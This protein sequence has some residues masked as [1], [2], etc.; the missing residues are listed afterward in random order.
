M[1]LFPNDQY[2]ISVSR[3]R[4]LLT[5]DC[6]HSWCGVLLRDNMRDLR[7]EKRLT[8][9]RE[10][11][12]GI[13]CL[14]VASN[15]TTVI[16][17]GQEKTLTT[18]DLR[19]ADPVR[20]I[21][22]DEEVLALSMT[23]DDAFL[24]TAGTG[25]TVKV[26]DIR[27]DQ[28]W[29]RC[30]AVERGHKLRVSGAMPELRVSSAA[31]GEQLLTAALEE[32]ALAS[33]LAKLLKAEVFRSLGV[34]AVRQK[35]FLEGQE[36]SEG[37]WL[38][39]GQPSEVFVVLQC[40]AQRFGAEL[41]SAAAA[42]DAAMVQRVLAQYQ[43]P[44]CRSRGLAP[45][46]LA[47]ENGHAPCLRLLLA[48]AADLHAADDAGETALHSAAWRGQKEAAECLLQAGAEAARVNENQDTALH[49]AA[50]NGH[51]AVAQLLLQHDAP[52]NAGNEAGDTP[53][54]LAAQSGH[55][56][57][58]RL[59]LLRGADLH[60]E[61]TSGETPLHLA[62]WRGQAAVASAL[63]EAKA[64]LEARSSSG[65]SALILGAWGGHRDLCGLLLRR[66]AEAQAANLRGDTALVLALRNN[67]LGTAQCLL[68]YLPPPLPKEAVLEVVDL[69]QAAERNQL[70]ADLAESPLRA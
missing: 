40:A 45:L 60:A 62:A 19:M 50:W 25:Q 35:L 13:N 67:D 41:V 54:H 28:A 5:W 11:H 31:S 1:S 27:N 17:A 37:S 26:W 51:L 7:A 64:A 10:R 34:P 2:A 63:L 70:A 14:A 29:Y 9:H 69:I 38:S 18:W 3:D 58:V 21:D 8:A 46:H 47:A 55:Q 33:S 61:L 66:N 30:P 4:C 52:I 20:I 57:L 15:Q 23:H 32:A 44:N 36:L 43:D 59:L 68:R 56:A 42:G 48:A 22:L 24:A 12:G 65:D 49:L 39:L 6:G 16:T 53:L